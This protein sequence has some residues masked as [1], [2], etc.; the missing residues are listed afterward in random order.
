MKL[1]TMQTGIKMLPTLLLA[2]VVQTFDSQV[3]YNQ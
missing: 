2:S 3:S 1:Q